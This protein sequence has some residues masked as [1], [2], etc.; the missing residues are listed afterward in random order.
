LEKALL[1]A[2]WNKWVLDAFE[3]YL[4]FETNEWWKREN[5]TLLKLQFETSKNRTGD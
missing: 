5:S 4:R 1:K 2:D 3:N